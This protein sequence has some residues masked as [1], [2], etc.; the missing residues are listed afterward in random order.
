[1]PKLRFISDR[2]YLILLLWISFIVS[3][4]AQTLS[5]D[6]FCTPVKYV[7]KI[8]NAQAEKIAKG[9]VETLS[10]EYFQQFVDTTSQVTPG[11]IPPGAYLIADAEKENL[12]CCLYKVIPFTCNI[13]NNH[14]D[15]AISV[16]DNQTGKVIPD[17][18]VFI[19]HT[20]IKYDVKSQTYRRHRTDKDGWVSVEVNGVCD[21]FPISKQYKLNPW[22]RFVNGAASV[23]VLKYIVRP[24]WFITSIPGD[25]IQ[26]IK[27]HYAYRSIYRIKNFPRRLKYKVKNLFDPDGNRSERKDECFV[28]LNKPRFRPGDSIKVK[29]YLTNKHGNPVDHKVVINLHNGKKQIPVD[30]LIPLRPGI[31]ACKFQLKPSY[32]LVL[33]KYYSITFT[34]TNWDYL[35]SESFKYEDYELRSTVYDLS[36][37]QEEYQPDEPVKITLSAKD[38]NNLPLPDARADISLSVNSLNKFD[39]KKLHFPNII[40]K[41]TVSIDPS[42]ESAITI[43]DSVFPPADLSLKLS[44]RFN[45]AENQG[46]TKDCYFIRH[47]CNEKIVF[48]PKGD[49]L[50]IDF[51]KAGVSMPV[52]GASLLTNLAPETPIYLPVII[53][54][55]P[56]VNSYRVKCD[57][58]VRSYTPDQ[59]GDGI[60]CSMEHTGDSLFVNVSNPR[61]LPLA[62]TLYKNNREIRR[63]TG[64]NP[65]VNLKASRKA[66]YYLSVQYVWAGTVRS[67]EYSASYSPAR[68]KISAI[69]PPVIYPGQKVTVKLAVTDEHNEPIPNADVTALGY[70][71][72]FNS[73]LSVRLPYQVVTR[74]GRTTFNSF[75]GRYSNAPTRFRSPLDYL[76]WRDRMRLDTIEMYKFAY[77][78]DGNYRLEL[79]SE[80]RKPLIAPYLV[81]AGTLLPVNMLYIDDVLVY[82]NEATSKRPYW[83]EVLPGRH[84]VRMRTTCKSVEFDV[85]TRPYVKYILSFD[86]DKY[87]F[88]NT[89][90]QNN[91]Y[92]S[93]EKQQ[94]IRSLIPVR[95]SPQNGFDY[96]QQGDSVFDIINDQERV[97]AGPFRNKEI[98]YH[99]IGNFRRP[100]L[101]DNEPFE[102]EFLTGVTK[103]RSISLFN[104]MSYSRP[105]LDFGESLLTQKRIDSLYQSYARRKMHDKARF[106]MLKSDNSGSVFYLSAE[107]PDSLRSKLLGWV[108]FNPESKA[109]GFYSYETHYIHNIPSGRYMLMLLLDDLTYYSTDDVYIQ[110]GS[111]TLRRITRDELQ[112]SPEVLTVKYPDAMPSFYYGKRLTEL[113]YSA[114]IS[115]NTKIKANPAYAGEILIHGVVVDARDRSPLVGVSVIVDGTNKG[116]IA[117][118]DGVYNLVVPA[119]YRTITFHYIGYKPQTFR[120]YESGELNVALE[121]DNCALDEVVV[122]GYGTQKRMDLT[123]SVTSVDGALQGRLAGIDASVIRIRG[124]S[125]ITGD[126]T[127]LYVVDGVVRGDIKDINPKEIQNMNVLKDA[128]A[129]AIYGAQGANGV[130]IITT[131]KGVT[132]TTTEARQ[133]MQQLLADDGFM[134][135]QA[136]G[137]R[138]H[139]SD[140][141]FWQPTLTTDK[142]GIASFETTFPDDI[143]KWKTWYVGLLP[144]KS[145]AIASTEI[146]SF[147]PVSAQLSL[148]RF[149]TRGDKSNV[150]GKTVN[151]TGDT[152][153]VE[154]SFSVNNRTVKSEQARLLQVHV[155]TLGVQADRRDSIQIEY[156]FR[157][158]DGLKD[159]ERRAIPVVSCGTIETT[160]DFFALDNDTTITLRANAGAD[161]TIVYAESDAIESIKKELNYMDGYQ[162][163]CNE[164]CASKL[165][166][167]LIERLIN[168]SEGKPYT[169]DGKIRHLI[170]KLEKGSNDKKLWGWWSGM[171]TE[172]WIS[173]HVLEALC[174]AREAGFTINKDFTSMR[175]D[176]LGLFDRQPA[177]VQIRI[178]RLLHQLNPDG[179]YESELN[180]IHPDKKSMSEQLALLELKTRYHK[181]DADTLLRTCQRDLFGN[182]Y[183]GDKKDNLMGNTTEATLS[184]YRILRESGKYPQMLTKIRNYLLAQRRKG[185]WRNTYESAH[186]LETIVPDMIALK[187][188]LQRS[189]L[190]INGYVNLRRDTLPLRLSMPR[191]SAVT[192]HKTGSYPVYLT[193]YSRIFRE[194]PEA[195]NKGFTINTHWENGS[196]YLPAGKPVKLIAE[197]SVKEDQE[198]VMVE[199]PIPAGCSYNDKRQY[200]KESHREY[201]ADKVC[202]YLRNLRQGQSTYEVSL[203]PRFSGEYKLN[204]AKAE[205]MYFPVFFGRTGIRE[206]SIGK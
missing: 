75:S 96:L 135:K 169:S 2:T 82:T 41:K 192:I 116:G 108:L 107:L 59:S 16:L 42:G 46:K 50:L 47:D 138:S 146:R 4:Q 67:A 171:E 176:L 8:S 127:P 202:I 163:L 189:V 178:L 119:G 51:R 56:L 76:A 21:F 183:W 142:N 22:K 80:G 15:L 64:I 28:L 187:G 100:F 57:G 179:N 27:R 18:L 131:R 185:C 133:M 71:S 13:L 124:G 72:K 69:V 188:T 111:Y 49:S 20:R 23:P 174:Q 167:L 68:M 95:R 101:P 205:K 162:H 29:A 70:T 134:A 14:T 121:S 36:V 40:W 204:P 136:G 168:K 63:G 148:P 9:K 197:V 155:D 31:F 154:T 198:Y 200:W 129:T 115:S 89:S 52:T 151:Y 139:F 93:T 25:A 157:R 159:G 160:G 141:A 3:F 62:F 32:E 1:M 85:D 7:Y 73:D 173:T 83:F 53:P 180:K 91:K 11:N 39:G 24:V 43:P 181:V 164:Q 5:K 196:T 10:S 140:E 184:A 195:V 203:E 44:V 110:G 113:N 66:C 152:V 149:L 143:T 84:H 30:T 98:T 112:Y 118:I 105:S 19:N 106:T 86:P 130:V 45:N 144:R 122:V 81:H 55:N 60:L 156:S 17:A 54:M 79:P 74:K 48:E 87:G 6:R 186:I 33:D 172:V 177:S 194:N 78:K 161:S 88:R 191:N 190:D 65:V 147:I 132:T 150:I 104:K 38:E 166:A 125:S 120:K 126:A 182:C 206:V 12:R 201:F 117:N 90:R 158:N 175:I 102:Y 61:H 58:I 199:I 193:S 109:S 37:S 92:S 35:A 77:P 99:S 114:P 165:K 123:G 128:A 26:S 170:D 97:I 153:Q 103:M 34:S 94:L 137:L 145:A